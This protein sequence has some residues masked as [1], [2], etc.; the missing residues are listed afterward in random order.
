MTLGKRMVGRS[1][2][3]ALKLAKLARAFV[4]LVGLLGTYA[5]CVGSAMDE[6]ASESV[7][8][9]SEALTTSQVWSFENAANWTITSGTAT[10]QT[11]TTHDEGSFSLQLAASAFVAV[12][13]DGVSKPSAVSPLLALDVMIPTQAGPYYFGAVQ[14]TI[15]VPS[16]NINSQWVNQRELSVPTGVWQTLSFQLPSNIY[17]QLLSSSFNDLQITIGLNPPS[18]VTQPFRFDNLC[19]LPSPSCVGQPDGTFCDDSV[20]CTTGN[21][22]TGGVCGTVTTPPPGSACDPADDVMGFENFPAWQVTN[23]AAALAPSTTHVQGV[24]S[25]QV[26]TSNFT[27][28]TSVALATLHKVSQTLSLRVQKPTNQPNPSWQGDLTLAMSVPSRGINFS[29]NVGL[30]GKPNGSFFE[31]TFQVPAATVQTLANNTY[32]DLK[33]SISINPPSGQ[34]GFY[35]LDDLHFVPVSSCTGALNKTACEDNSVCTQGDSCQGGVCGAAIICNDGNLCTDDSC[36]AVTGCVFT[37]N[38]ATCN[39]GNACTSADHC[40]GGACIGTLVTCNDANPCTDDSCNTTTGCVFTPNTAICDDGNAC[41][42][43]DQ[44]SGGHCVPGGP[45]NCDDANPCTD[46][47]CLQTTGCVHANNTAPC[48]DNNVCT[49]TVTSADTCSGGTCVP[50]A[51]VSCD[52]GSNCTTDVCVNPT[53][54][55]HSSA[56]GTGLCV[57]NN[58]CFPATCTDLHA[59]CGT[60]SDGCGGT[61]DCSAT[62]PNDGT[63]NPALQC[64]PP[65]SFDQK[66]G[67]NIC[68]TLLEDLVISTPITRDIPKC[69]ATTDFTNP[70]ACIFGV[71]SG[72]I[73]CC[74]SEGA[75]LGDPACFAIDTVTDVV[76]TV[77]DKG[78]I[79]CAPRSPKEYLEKVL[80][81]SISN[82]E[83]WTSFYLT[84]GLSELLDFD[85][86]VLS[87]AGSVAPDHVRSL[88]RDLTAPMYN[89]GVG[90]GIANYA[91]MDNVRLISSDFPTAEPYLVGPRLAITM[92]PVIIMKPEII[93]PLFD[94]ANNGVD[95]TKFLTDPSVDPAYIAAVDTFI[96]ELVHVRQYADLGRV[97]FYTQ[98]LGNIIAKDADPTNSSFEQE[99]YTYEFLLTELQGGRYCATRKDYDNAQI[100][101]FHLASA[102]P[103][104]MCVFP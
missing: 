56:C 18:G 82:L 102:V 103:E 32:N 52:D 74:F 69:F 13:G 21:T 59:E 91:D 11:S 6:Q 55:M 86:A 38:T 34:T 19:F 77:Y 24:R 1:V 68:E 9:T 71:L 65:S 39:D 99:A 85:V 104:N 4:L 95:Y 57:A 64:L 92:G 23:G 49:G 2:G 51:A 36:N 87:N 76:T 53:G 44:C 43:G 63:C 10:K 8:N 61:V 83:D 17:Q 5:G 97:N 27:T 33:F 79:Y 26:T 40:S 7:A 47:S 45:T 93:N 58:C 14:M 81:G 54:C 35:L 90:N 89:G 25:L 72:H 15:N 101:A 98:Y 12:R 73:D 16:L 84:G 70:L 62:C 22:C 37:P 42:T 66:T 3:K 94:A 28:V 80:N 60:P 48:D 67:F 46:D 88:I 78:T 20:T 41:T 29:Q 30:T 100:Q 50:G 96:H 75:C 31:L